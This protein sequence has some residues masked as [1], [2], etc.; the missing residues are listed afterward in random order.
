MTAAAKKTRASE[1]RR[2]KVVRWQ[3]LIIFFVLCALAAGS[4]KWR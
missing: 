4:A 2:S 3:G 1:R